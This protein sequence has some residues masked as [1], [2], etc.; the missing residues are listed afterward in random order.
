MNS[1][2]HDLTE[3]EALI[4]ELEKPE[5]RP[6]APNLP[7]QT[8]EEMRRA[9][10]TPQADGLSPQAVKNLWKFAGTA[11][12][13]FL[14]LFIVASFIA[15]L[16]NPSTQTGEQEN[17]ITLPTRTPA[18]ATPTAANGQDETER[19]DLPAMTSLSGSVDLRERSVIFGDR[20]QLVGYDLQST[21]GGPLLRLHW[22]PLA[23]LDNNF[24][25]FVHFMDKNGDLVLQVDGSLFT[26]PLPDSTDEIESEIYLPT[27]KLSSSG[28]YEIVFGLYDTHSYERLYISVLGGQNYNGSSTTF[29][30]TS[31]LPQSDVVAGDE[32]GITPANIQ[33]GEELLLTSYR[34][35]QSGDDFS[36]SLQWQPLGESI[37]DYELGM[38]FVNEDGVVDLEMRKPVTG[39]GRP[40]SQW[41]S[42]NIYYDGQSGPLF[43]SLEGNY[44][45][46]LSLLNP[47]TGERATV[48]AP[49][50]TILRDNNT[51]VRL[52]SW[53]PADLQ[54]RI[55]LISA[56]PAPGTNLYDTGGVPTT[57][58][59]EIGYELGSADVGYLQWGLEPVGEGEIPRYVYY[60]EPQGKVERGSGT[61]TAEV[62]M[63]STRPDGLAAA[64]TANIGFMVPSK[65]M[66]LPLETMDDLIWP[67]TPPEESGGVWLVSIVQKER[68]STD[69]P[70]DLEITLGYE[71]ESEEDVFIKLSYADENWESFAGNGR[72]PVDGLQ[73]P[74][75]LDNNQGEVTIS[76]T[77]NPNEALQIVGSENP[78]LLAELGYIQEFDDGRDNVIHFLAHETFGD[79]PLDLTTT[80]EVQYLP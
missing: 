62:V 22:L 14:L 46:V 17:V 65:Q 49:D 76:A 1:K 75:F 18:R 19:S 50:P 61:L 74:V 51:A 55:W 66:L 36:Y 11:V 34:L 2:D 68:P 78:V 71:F 56:D 64:V 21:A 5:I 24:H 79:Y 37:P 69:A 9:L 6:Y 3:F 38:Q 30:L 53:T 7:R 77:L 42:D 27:G 58:T 44:D 23:E 41:T 52:G 63:S 43:G 4:A 29:S 16:A 72:L 31:L 57:F 54:D 15:V 8:K 60:S 28:H 35:A 73:N 48:S 33:F 25:V 13:A 67:L 10:F 39:N 80:E 20:L 40:P 70:I 26:E 45:I 59:F 12:V 47:D 32:D